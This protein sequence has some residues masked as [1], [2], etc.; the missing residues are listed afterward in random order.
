MGGVAEPGNLLVGNGLMV[1]VSMMGAFKRQPLPARC[2]G[3]VNPSYW[4]LH[5]IVSYKALWQLIASP[6]YWEKTLHGSAPSLR[7]G[8]SPP[9][10]RLWPDSGARRW[11]ASVGLA[12][13]MIVLAVVAD[14][15]AGASAGTTLLIERGALV[16]SEGFDGLRWAYPPIPTFVA[17]ILDEALVVSIAGCVLGGAAGFVVIQRMYARGLPAWLQVLIVASIGL[18]PSTWYVFTQ[19]TDGMM[20]LALLVIALDGFERFAME[21]ETLG[22]FVTGLALGAAVVCDP[23]AIVYAVA[24]AVAAPLAAAA[25]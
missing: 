24:L 12:A 11:A 6:H 23:S 16:R 8:L 22:G 9:T 4:L 3:I 1:Y 21:G 20:G 13:P 2:L 17:G 25:R 19:D 18:V 10:P 15:R 14:R 7:I 5:S